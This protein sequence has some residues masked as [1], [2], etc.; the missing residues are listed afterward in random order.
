MVHTIRKEFWSF[1]FINLTNWKYIHIYNISDFAEWNTLRYSVFCIIHI[2]AK[3]THYRSP[4][5]RYTGNHNTADGVEKTHLNVARQ[6]GI[7]RAIKSISIFRSKPCKHTNSTTRTF[8]TA[9]HNSSTTTQRARSS[10]IGF[11]KSINKTTIRETQSVS[12]EQF[13]KKSTGC[14]HYIVTSTAF[15]Q[16]FKKISLQIMHKNRYWNDALLLYFLQTS[17]PV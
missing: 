3:C 12:Y 2:Y 7:H 1:L 17:V 4:D 13:R 10:Y 6:L 9:S 16:V 11:G 15:A 5:Y 14:L 8:P